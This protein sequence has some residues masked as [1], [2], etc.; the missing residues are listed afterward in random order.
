MERYWR[1][2][3][4]RRQPITDPLGRNPLT[5]RMMDWYFMRL[6]IV[7]TPRTITWWPAG[8]VSQAPERL[9][10]SAGEAEHVG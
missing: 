8:D 2:S 9:D 10:V 6:E 1:D 5:R 3:I 7:I 4:F